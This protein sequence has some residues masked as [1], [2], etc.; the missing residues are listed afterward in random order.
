MKRWL[1]IS[2][3]LVFLASPGWGQTP[4]EY[5]REIE[6][7]RQEMAELKEQIE[8]FHRQAQRLGAQEAGLVREVVLLER[9]L[10]LRRSLVE[11][12]ET[13]VAATAARVQTVADSL[14]RAREERAYLRALLAWRLR[15]IYKQRFAEPL[16]LLASA[17]S[18]TDAVNRFRYLRLVAE[19]DRARLWRF[20]HLT[21]EIEEK[22][23]TLRAHLAR[24]LADRRELRVELA[25][26]RQREQRRHQALGE[27]RTN[28]RA[29]LEAAQSLEQEVAQ[30]QA[31]IEE[32]EAK[33]LAALRA[34]RAEAKA[35][36]RGGME[37]PVVGPILASFG[38]RIHP[39][40][41]TRLQNQGIDIKASRGAVIRAAADG[42]VVQTRWWFNYGRLLILAHPGGIYTLYAHLDEFLVGEGERVYRG[43]SVGRVGSSG[44]LQDPFLH[45]EVREGTTAVNPLNWLQGK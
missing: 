2:V 9:E 43:Q 10:A 33:R 15:E 18:L 31:F 30:V 6:R 29:R 5:A 42:E 40:Y 12:R 27:V 1:G 28:R 17:P 8:S 36:E 38:P 41:K 23:A 24:L 19:H 39:V 14:A 25:E 4:E 34:G 26:L 45:F 7:R 21:A 11:A 3:G 37:W 35:P 32:L 13:Q 44:S 20:R 22:E 16:I